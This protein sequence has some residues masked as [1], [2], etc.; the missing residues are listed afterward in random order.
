VSVSAGSTDRTV[1]GTAAQSRTSNTSGQQGTSTTTGQTQTQ[2]PPLRALS[3]NRAGGVGTAPNGVPIGNPGS[4]PGS[5]EQPYD[6]GAR[7]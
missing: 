7:R 4:G 1:N 6:S 2:T 3:T 5:P